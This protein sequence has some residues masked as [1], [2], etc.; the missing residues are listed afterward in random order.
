MT[1]VQRRAATPW[2]DL[3]PPPATD[4]EIWLE[5]LVGTPVGSMAL[6]VDGDVVIVEPPRVGGREVQLPLGRDFK[7]TYRVRGVPCEVR[8]VIVRGPV[9]GE[10]GYGARMTSP[11]T[12]LQRRQFVRVP[13]TLPVALRDATGAGD[14]FTATS[15]NVSV[16]GLGVSSAREILPGELLDASLDCGRFG[17]L[18][19]RVRVVWSREDRQAR[20]W[21]AGMAILDMEPVD[22]RRLRGYVLDR[23]RVLRR[24]EL[25]LE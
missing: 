6:G 25:G 17:V 9:P 19:M 1:T 8:A 7:I 4:Q 16:G 11:P 14:R 22:R 10:R 24:R 12:R 13:A 21:T 2:I 3:G 15:L 5:G 20:T 18:P 23:Q